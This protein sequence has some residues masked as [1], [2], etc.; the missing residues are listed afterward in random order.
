[1]A[2]RQPGDARVG[3]VA[4]VTRATDAALHYYHD[5]ST[6]PAIEVQLSRF[7]ALRVGDELLKIREALLAAKALFEAC[8]KIHPNGNRDVNAKKMTLI[9]LLNEL[10]I[11]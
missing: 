4:V 3:A 7:A 5:Q 10:E 8:D 6:V 2:S 11:R 1:M 9:R